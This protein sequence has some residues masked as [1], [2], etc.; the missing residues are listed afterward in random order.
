MKAILEFDLNEHDDQ[1]AHLRAIKA[2]DMALVLWDMDQYLRGLIKHG[3]LDDKVYDALEVARDKLYEIMNSHDDLISQIVNN[4]SFKLLESIDE[5]V[6][7]DSPMEVYRKYEPL[8]LKMSNPRTEEKI[9]TDFDPTDREPNAK[10]GRVRAAGGGL[11][12]LLKL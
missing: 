5:M 9:L 8:Y 12:D 7:S 10:G 11:A 1:V 4:D 6:K 2:L 3:D